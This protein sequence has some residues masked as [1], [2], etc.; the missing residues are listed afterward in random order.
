MTT[1]EQPTLSK[2]RFMSGLQCL[3]RLYLDTY[4]RK[5]ADPIGPGQQALFDTGSAVGAL[6]RQR[7]PGGHLI[8][9]PYYDHPGAEASTTRILGDQSIPAM[10]EAAFSFEGIRVRADILQRVDET[11]FD[12]IEVKSSTKLKEENIPDGAI[13]LHVLQ[14][15][16]LQIRSV[17]LLHIDNTYV[18]QGGAYDL[19]KLFQLED[20]TEEVHSYLQSISGSLEE[21]TKTLQA[22]THPDIGIGPQCSKPYQCSFYGHCHQGLPEHHVDQLPRAGQPLLLKL[23][24]AGI[25]D[26]Q[27]L[28]GGFQGLTAA[29][30]RVRE[31]V[32]TGNPYLGPGL[33]GE[34][35]SLQYPI[36]F[37][38]FETFNPALPLHPG[39]R[40]Y[41]VMPFQWSLRIQR[42]SGDLVH[43]EY[44]HDGA[45]DPREPFTTSLLEAMESEGSIVVYSSFERS[46]LENLAT[47]F[48]QYSDQLLALCARLFD[49]LKVIQGG[50]YHPDFH[51]SYSIK[52]VLPALVPDM[53][54]K[55]LGIQDGGAASAAYAEL[56]DAALKDSR[57]AEI[58]TDLLL[59]CGQDT[60]AMVK[61]LEVLRT[62]TG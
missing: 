62:N 5:L 22:T 45:D 37:L 29:H 12:L 54:Y 49:L 61:L 13:Q 48:P 50:Y 53:T 6:A 52:A 32:Q 56:L 40:P 46:R 2:T 19:E 59:Y 38:D 43:R 7:F 42:E 10:Y 24:E 33:A 8:A 4:D 23:K 16:G 3:K 44:L 14:G 30:Q 35:A 41:Q 36:H 51:G 39:T 60:M 27:N 21:M 34:L 17:Y 18:Y 11:T 1:K 58:R 47:F 20:I 9:E 26:I 57:R 28:P 15:T 31:A 25:D 55:N